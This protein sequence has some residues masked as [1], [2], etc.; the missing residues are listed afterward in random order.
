MQESDHKRFGDR[1]EAKARNWNGY[2]WS[3]TIKRVKIGI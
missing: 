2:K 3:G 1:Y